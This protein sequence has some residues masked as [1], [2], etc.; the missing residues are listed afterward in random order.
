MDGQP[1]IVNQCTVAQSA[2]IAPDQQFNNVNRHH[3]T[4]DQPDLVSY[5]T[6]AQSAQLATNCQPNPLNQQLHQQIQQTQAD[7]TMS[8]SNSSMGIKSGTAWEGSHVWI[9]A[10]FQQSQSATFSMVNSTITHTCKA[11]MYL[12]GQ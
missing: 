5:S 12:L 9:A 2:A 8:A 3:F 6:T 1:N 4:M 7:G 10:M 11:Q